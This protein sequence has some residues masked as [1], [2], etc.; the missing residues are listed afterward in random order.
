M[1]YPP[2]LFVTDEKRVVPRVPRN[3][4]RRGLADAGGRAHDGTVNVARRLLISVAAVAGIATALPAVAHATGSNP[5]PVAGPVVILAP[6][7]MPGW[8]GP[9]KV[10][11]WWPQPW[12]VVATCKTPYVAGKP[13]DG[14]SPHGVPSWVTVALGL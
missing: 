12:G 5:P 1:S 10:L 11:E 6:S 13:A 2:D 7:D 3:H 9:D 8:C 4:A 14:A